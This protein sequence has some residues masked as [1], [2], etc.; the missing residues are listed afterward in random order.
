MDT[1]KIFAHRGFSY[2]APENTLASFLKAMHT[3]ADGIE[4]DVQLSKDGHVVVIH[5][6]TLNR[7]S[8]GTGFVKDFTLSELKELDFGKW[9]SDKFLGEK[10]PTLEEVLNLTSNWSGILNIELKNSIIEY[11]NLEKK[12]VEVLK[13]HNRIDNILV[14][15]FNHNSLKIIK[16][17]YPELKIAL[18]YDAS[19][20]ID[21]EYV[22]LFNA[23]AIHPYFKDVTKE[24]V[25]KACLNNLKVNTYTVNTPSDI[26][27]LNKLGVNGIF[28][29]DPILAKQAL[30]I[31]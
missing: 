14:S 16:N 12:V 15:S 4:F 7:T 24:L 6:E 25:Q 27:T 17:I 1:V 10:I 3:E 11:P 29:D 31:K 13:K 28:S 8:T 21:F 30:K 26:V 20:S 9:F 5:D 2:R 22:K 23:Y 18:L 19:Q